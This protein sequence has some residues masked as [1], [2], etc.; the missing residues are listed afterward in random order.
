MIPLTTRRVTSSSHIAV[1]NAGGRQVARHTT[2]GTR[3]GVGGNQVT[4]AQ[5]GEGRHQQTR[6]FF[7]TCPSRSALNSAIQ[8]KEKGDIVRGESQSEGSLGRPEHAVISTFDLFSIG[9]P[10]S[11]SPPYLSRFEVT[12]SQLVPVA[13][14][15][16]APCGLATYL[17]TT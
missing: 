13:H 12:A 2:W 14:T 4:V 17:S 9:G 8:P 16:S 10:W 1:R 7:Q 5:F 15:P 3:N 11:Y 6:G